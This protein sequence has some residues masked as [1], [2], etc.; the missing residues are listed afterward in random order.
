MIYRLCDVTVNIST[1]D[2][3]DFYLNLSISFEP[4]LIKSQNLAT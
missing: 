3:V 1:K 2:R 4:Q